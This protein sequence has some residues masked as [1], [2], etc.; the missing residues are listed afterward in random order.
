MSDRHDCAVIPDPEITQAI[1]AVFRSVL[2]SDVAVEP[3]TDFFSAGGNSILAARA[4]VRLR[5]ELDVQITMNDVLS[6]RSPVALAVNIQ[7]GTR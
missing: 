3:D 1:I 7:R 2:D 5:R 6:C 4:V